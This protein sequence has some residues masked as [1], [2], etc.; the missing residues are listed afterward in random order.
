MRRIEAEEREAIRRG[1]RKR[2]ANMSGE[3]KL[4]RASVGVTCNEGG[5]ARTRRQRCDP[6]LAS[7]VWPTGE[8]RFGKGWTG[9]DVMAMVVVWPGREVGFLG[10]WI[11]GR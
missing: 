10:G 3:L 11:C 7:R 4:G 9:W 1:H 8:R 6:S 2:E 5:V